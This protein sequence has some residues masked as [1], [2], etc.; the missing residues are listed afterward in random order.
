M[1][2]RRAKI[3]CTLGPA[4]T[5]PEMIDRMVRSGMDVARLNFSHG[6]PEEHAKRVA[7]VRRASAH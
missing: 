1:E 3:V 4:S 7:A 2:L 5:S 6:K